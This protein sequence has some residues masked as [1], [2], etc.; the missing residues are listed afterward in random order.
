[1]PLLGTFGAASARGFGE[2]TVAVTIPGAPTGVSATATGRTTANVSFTAPASNG[3]ATI[4]SYTAVSTPG[5]ITATIYQSGSGT[6]SVTG[7][8]ANTSYTFVVYATNSVG[9]SAN[10]SASNSITTQANGFLNITSAQSSTL[11]K[12]NSLAVYTSDNSIYWGGMGYSCPY[13]AIVKLSTDGSISAQKIFAGND[14]RQTKIG[15]DGSVYGLVT[16]NTSEVIKFNSSLGVV[17]QKRLAPSGQSGY[18]FSM[19]G[20]DNI[21]I[22]NKYN[23]GCC[24][25]YP[26]ISKYNSSGTYQWGFQWTNYGVGSF[27][28][29]ADSSGNTY[30]A[31]N[32][33][34]AGS[35]SGTW[36]IKRNSSGTVLSNRIFYTPSG[37]DVDSPVFIETDG[38]S[39][40]VVAPYGTGAAIVSLS[41]SSLSVNWG[42]SL[43]G[44]SARYFKIGIDSNTGDVYTAGQIATSGTSSQGAL[45]VKYNSSGTLQWQRKLY[46][47]VA[48]RYLYGY[49][50]AINSNSQFAIAGRIENGSISAAYTAL[51]P[52]DGSATGTYN[53]T[54]SQFGT[55]PLTY[56]AATYTDG[57]ISISTT[58][59]SPTQ[60][61]YTSSP[62][63]TS[64]S[65]QNGAFVSYKTLV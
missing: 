16:D 56:D 58:T 9:N 23:A 46:W 50:I 12:A 35:R 22:A 59:Q 7:L 19:D 1:M 65:L 3:G 11:Q 4:T 55:V 14:I 42:R 34:A 37:T 51:L 13:G 25:Y 40:Y 47:N 48:G 20:S 33:L 41:C 49:G 21:Y 29:C 63:N 26:F 43:T 8:T 53:I 5:S 64:Y 60:S 45:I 61:T 52:T 38:T 44:T 18:P 6:I 2:L 10:S 31:Q 27:Y 62:T 36:V 15:T 17:W 57:S 54:G 30:T 32:V 28:I 24:N 39:V